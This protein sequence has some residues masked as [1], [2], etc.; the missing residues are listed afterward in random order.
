[1][2]A[3]LKLG[4]IK[5][6][7]EERWV[8]LMSDEHADNAHSDLGLIRAHH[9]QAAERGAPILKF[10]DTFCA[11][12][13]KWDRR[14]DQEQLRPELRGNGYL[15]RL[16]DFHER[17][18]LPY[19]RHIAAVGDG[20]HETSILQHHQTHLTERLVDRLR[21]AGSPA[22]LLGFTGFIRIAVSGSCKSKSWDLHYHHG[23]GGGGEVTRGMIDNNRT[24]G[25]Y[26]A[27]I[28]YSGHIHRR[29]MDENIVIALNHQGGV[30]KKT[31]LFLRGGAYK[32]EEGAGGWHVERGRSARPAGGW[33]LRITMARPGK[34]RV[35]SVQ[36]VPA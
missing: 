21:R 19:A 13:G 18:Y 5:N 32:H 14:A 7:N 23:Y 29:N 3:T 34:D 30:E 11:M 4:D 15:D 26:A 20:N 12:Q 9:E 2:V 35:L 36:A 6:V 17:L 10:G 25:Q 28:Y 33:W 31:Q 8:L 1:M 16:M 24:R 22:V 27:D